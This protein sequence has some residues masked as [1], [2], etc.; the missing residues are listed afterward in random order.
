MKVI[1]LIVIAVIIVFIFA[2][3]KKTE[4]EPKPKE[5][6]S[7]K[8]A[9]FRIKMSGDEAIDSKNAFEILGIH[10][11]TEMAEYLKTH[12]WHYMDDFNPIT[13]QCTVQLVDT[14]VL[15]A[16]R[17]FVDGTTQYEMFNEVEYKRARK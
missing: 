3:R 10:D 5:D 8:K 16:C 7:E 14:K 9:V 12:T 6:S 2:R 13:Q 4:S 1:I 11:S 15:D 17:P